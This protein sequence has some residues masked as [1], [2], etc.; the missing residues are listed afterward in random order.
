MIGCF[1]IPHYVY[2]VV[3]SGKFLIAFNCL[4]MYVA[5]HGTPSALGRPYHVNHV[6]YGR[7]GVFLR[8]RALDVP[9]LKHIIFFVDVMSFDDAVMSY[10]MSQHHTCIGHM[11]VYYKRATNTSVG[12]VMV[13]S[14]VH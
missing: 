9:H 12:G 3:I 8:R 14:S 5:S 7:F 13:S 11:T 1:N 2:T 6:N 10:M 4:Y